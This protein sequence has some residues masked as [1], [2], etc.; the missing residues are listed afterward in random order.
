MAMKLKGQ[1]VERLPKA[2]KGF[3]HLLVRE[4][5]SLKWNEFQINYSTAYFK[6]SPTAMPRKYLQFL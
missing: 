1:I 5:N 3:S 2:S 6:A 4:K